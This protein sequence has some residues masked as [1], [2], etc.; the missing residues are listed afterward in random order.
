MT[1]QNYR[2]IEAQF[3]VACEECHA[4]KI[5]CELALANSG[6]A[7]SS[8]K[9][10]ALNQR[11]CLFSL[12]SRTG[13]PRK[14]PLTSFSSSS[15]SPPQPLPVQTNRSSKSLQA[16][17]TTQSPLRP[18]SSSMRSGEQMAGDED[19]GGNEENEEGM[20]QVHSLVQQNLESLSHG[21]QAQQMWTPEAIDP[22]EWNASPSAWAILAA[23]N[24]QQSAL[25]LASSGQLEDLLQ[26]SGGLR[27]DGW[28]TDTLSHHF[29]L[30]QGSGTGG[31]L[32]ESGRPIMDPV[33]EPTLM[34]LESLTALDEGTGGAPPTSRGARE[35][36]FLDALELCSKLHTTCQ[37]SMI[38]DLLT[39]AGQD[40]V[41]SVL[42]LFGELNQAAF[43]LQEADDHASSSLS[44]SSET[45]VV[46]V[47][48]ME[49]TQVSTGII[50]YNF[51]RHHYSTAPSDPVVSE[52]QWY[53][54]P[55]QPAFSSDRPGPRKNGGVAKSS[56]KCRD[57]MHERQ[58]GAR[59]SCIELLIRLE[60]SL[61][62]F[63]HVMSK[64]GCLHAGQRASP[65][66][67]VTCDC[68]PNCVLKIDG[69]RSQVS[70]LL[71]QFRNYWD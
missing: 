70:A 63:R 28:E 30:Q 42:K 69:A 45:K 19:G 54:P 41:R 3:R 14:Q 43:A 23:N 65:P 58:L 51:Q 6:G 31:S 1:G 48:L 16:G 7:G 10:C 8:C 32:L 47:A 15:A 71:K 18:M 25:A 50:Q 26:P 61:I 44:S 46:R 66:Q 17:P 11:R 56:L 40:Q 64:I 60:F 36:G 35:K 27:G 37:R 53:S 5:R 33:A 59:L 2:A 4:R 9:A 13:R 68:W 12:R 38:L 62:R 22:A 55:E 39:E 29:M 21:Q 49:A 24:P 20:E 34:R 67:R 52:G 57:T